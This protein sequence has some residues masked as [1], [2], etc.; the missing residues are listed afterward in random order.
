M[1][2]DNQVVI[3]TKES[4]NEVNLIKKKFNITDKQFIEIAL[5]A[6]SNMKD[7]I[8]N[9]LVDKSIIEKQ[10]MKVLNKISKIESIANLSKP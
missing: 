10:K 2:S 4:K 8:V 1:S 3:S 5:F 6:I 7:D 9:I